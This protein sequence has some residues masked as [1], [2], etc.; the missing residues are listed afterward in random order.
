MS[1]EGRILAFGASLAKSGRPMSLE[2]EPD[3]GA[4]GAPPPRNPWVGRG[5]VVAA[6]ALWGVVVGLRV[7]QGAG[8][9]TPSAAVSREAQEDARDAGAAA[10]GREDDAH[11]AS[12]RDGSSGGG[13]AE[14]GKGALDG[15][16]ERA[17]AEA[18]RAEEEAAAGRGRVAKGE[19]EGPRKAEDDAPRDPRERLPVGAWAGDLSA[20]EAVFYAVKSGGSMK[21]VANLYKLFY[22]EVLAWNPGVDLDRE[23]PPGTKVA[24]YRRGEGEVS[25]S[26]GYAGEGSL[27]GGVPMVDGPGRILR[28]E[29]WKSYA[30]GANVAMMDAILREWS[31]RYPKDRPVLVGNMAQRTGGRLKP[32]STHQSGRDV[33]L[34]YPQV[35]IAGEEYNW[36]EMNA[37][38]LDAARTWDLLE[39]LFESGAVELVLIDTG[40]QKLLHE[41]ALAT[42]KVPKGELGHWLEYPR[43]PGEAESFVRHH[44]GHVDHM[45]VRFACRPEEG[46]CK[47]RARE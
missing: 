13:E 12:E 35:E 9:G 6:L 17:L 36:R 3:E 37:K 41:H 14:V 8:R 2:I 11:Y 43:R 34:S 19:G 47:S 16:L 39:L 31:R 10:E 33:D 20:P 38:N 46:R 44:A 18:E 23:L 27:V 26:V 42:G 7:E 30:T 29:P 1:G 15:L 28:M 4:D 25:E 40:L 22:H 45:H 5:L 24:V 32:H 21:R